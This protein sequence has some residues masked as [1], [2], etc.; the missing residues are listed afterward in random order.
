MQRLMACAPHSHLLTLCPQLHSM[1]NRHCSA[2]VTVQMGKSEKKCL[3]LCSDSTQTVQQTDI[4]KLLGTYFAKGVA[5]AWNV[6]GADVAKL[7][8]TE[9]S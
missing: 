4:G 6:A 7:V 5:W 1:K 8:P 9:V 2:A 3:G